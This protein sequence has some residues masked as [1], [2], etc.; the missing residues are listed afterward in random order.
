MTFSEKC[1]KSANSSRSSK[2]DY[3]PIEIGSKTLAIFS[4]FDF[5]RTNIGLLENSRPTACYFQ[6]NSWK[7]WGSVLGVFR[8]ISFHTILPTYIQSGPALY[9]MGYWMFTKKPE[10]MKKAFCFNFCA[11]HVLRTNLSTSDL[12]FVQ[13]TSV[14]KREPRGTFLS[15]GLRPRLQKTFPRFPFFYFG[16]LDKPQIRRGQIC[17]QTWQA[18]KSKQNTI[19]SFLSEPWI[20]SA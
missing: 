9:R 20:Y 10:Q 12:R 15:L 19:I 7:L 8:I 11:C 16:N 14:E 6:W 4:K 5:F 18:Q 2:I 3:F 17:P 1:L 13:V